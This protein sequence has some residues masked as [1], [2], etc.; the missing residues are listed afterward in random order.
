MPVFPSPASSH[1]IAVPSAFTPYLDPIEPNVDPLLVDVVDDLWMPHVVDRVHDQ[2][3]LDLRERVPVAVVV[4]C[5]VGGIQL[6]R[7]AALGRGRG[8]G[9]HKLALARTAGGAAPVSLGSR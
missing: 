4:V 1:A 7:V 2:L 8:G 5:D 6:G 3:R 9:S